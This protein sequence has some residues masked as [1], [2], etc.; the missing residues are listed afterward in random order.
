[1]SNIIGTLPASLQNGTTA[2]ASQ[3]MAD[4]NYIVNQVNANAQANG[5]FSPGS[6]V[7]I[8]VF[9]ASGTYTPTT[10]ANKAIIEAVGGG[11]AGGGAVGQTNTF[12]VGSGGW[13]GGYLKCFISNGLQ[14]YSGTAVTIGAGGTGVAASSG[15]PGA[16]TTFGSVLTAR[17]GAQG[18]GASSSAINAPP[19]NGG[20]LNNSSSLIILINRNGEI[21]TAGF[22]TNN[23][24]AAI[25]GWGG[26][27]GNSPFGSGGTGDF[28]AGVGSGSPTGFTAGHAGF[29]AGAGG[30][31]A[32]YFVNNG[33]S[34]YGNQAGWAG[35]AGLLIAYE[36][37]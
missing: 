33:G 6:L 36:Y 5:A 4:L 21:G 32:A 7:N 37:A 29:G 9:S 31:G 22:W 16:D 35:S 26:K 11:G 34:G 1:M 18:V 14:G 27:G 24:G 12:Q 19:F 2:D 8:Q 10:G 17:G 15:N 30:G 13:S 23:S 28:M 20:I 3:V 25:Y